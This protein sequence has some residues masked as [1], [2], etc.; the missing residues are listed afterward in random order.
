MTGM[1]PYC[2]AVRTVYALILFAL[3][4]HLLCGAMAFSADVKPLTP[5]VQNRLRMPISLTA[6]A[7]AVKVLQLL[8]KMA[9]FSLIADTSVKGEI[10]VSLKTVPFSTALDLICDQNGWS[11]RCIGETIAVSARAKGSDG[12]PIVVDDGDDIAIY[13]MKYAKPA[14]IQARLSLFLDAKKVQVDERTKS[15]IIKATKAELARVKQMLD[16]LDVPIPQVSVITRV[17][18]IKKDALKDIGIDWT[19][20]NLDI[21]F[22]TGQLTVG[23]DYLSALKALEQDG[24]AKSLA[25]PGITTIDGKEASVFLGDKVPMIK[26]EIDKEGK[27]TETVE[28]LEIG[29]RLKITPRVNEKGFVTLDLEPEISSLAK[30]VKGSQGEYPQTSITQFKTTV[31]VSSGQTVAIGGL[32]KYQDFENINKT[33][34]LG[35]LPI[36]GALFTS[37]KTTRTESEIVVFVTPY[38]VDAEKPVNVFYADDIDKKTSVQNPTLRTIPPVPTGEAGN[39]TGTGLAGS[40]AHSGATTGTAVLTNPPVPPVLVVKPPIA[41]P[42]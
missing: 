7:E 24:R 12:K 41:V 21:S 14:D 20:G 28:F 35:D 36:I 16:K 31:M 40:G 1:K 22:K 26:R 29:V 34:L 6:Q 39:S 11:W 42:K 3:V 10:T 27:I 13:E 15:V 32:F 25:G 9:K 18:E 4:A 8:A 33:P 2:S 37:K 19:F 23:L 30:Y 38:I 5:Q 17:E